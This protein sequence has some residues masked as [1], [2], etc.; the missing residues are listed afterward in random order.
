V[1]AT[2]TRLEEGTLIVQVFA[3]IVVGQS[4]DLN[5]VAESHHLFLLALH[6]FPL[7]S[8]SFI[9]LVLRHLNGGWYDDRS[10]GSVELSLSIQ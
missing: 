3:V 8:Y 10:R 6:G 4:S 7:F 2:S 1:Q 9:R 5:I